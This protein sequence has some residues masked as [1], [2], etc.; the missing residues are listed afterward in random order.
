MNTLFLH[1]L[2]VGIRVRC[3]D[4]YSYGLLLKGYSAFLSD[5]T[6]EPDLSYSIVP[7]RDSTFDIVLDGAP[8]EEARDDYELLYL[9]EKGMT[10][11][12]QKRRQNL[13]FMHAAAL[14]YRG[15]ILLLVAPS[16]SGKSTTTW[17]LVNNGFR[18]LS[19]ELAPIDPATF[20]VHP[21]PHALCLKAAPPEPF[22][23]PEQTLRTSYTMHVPVECLPGEPCREPAPLAAIFFLRYD[24]KAGEPS[25]KPVSKAEAGARIYSNSLNLLAHSRYGL[26]AALKVAG[27][28]D[29]YELVTSDLQ[30]TCA[31]IKSMIRCGPHA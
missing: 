12:V 28:S 4:P 13:L 21:Y 22:G 25:L 20:E 31:L 18:Y 11:E 2:G 27:H 23:L 5:G 16:G 3:P 19:D 1:V 24:P 7:K 6:A 26:D 10:L 15:R 9:F 14:E 29:N 17:A 30:Q 8:A